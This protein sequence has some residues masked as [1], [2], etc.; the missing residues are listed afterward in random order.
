MHEILRNFLHFVIVLYLKNK[1]YLIKNDTTE[2]DKL[3]IKKL[4]NNMNWIIKNPYIILLGATK[5]EK[6]EK[7]NLDKI[8]NNFEY[9]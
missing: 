7:P 6:I 1:I 2:K 4:K 3:N 8:K 5:Y 9:K